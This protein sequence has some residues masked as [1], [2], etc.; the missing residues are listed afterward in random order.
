[1]A[2]RSEA[3]SVD[4]PE[5][6]PPPISQFIDGDPVKVDSPSQTRSVSVIES[7]PK[8]E[9]E[10]SSTSPSPPAGESLSR[11]PSPEK[12][13][14]IKLP[15]QEPKIKKIVLADKPT[16]NAPPPQPAKAGSKRKLAVR[17]EIENSK[18]Q[19]ITNENVPPKS[20]TDKQSIRDKAGGR[21]LKELASIR[22]EAREKGVTITNTRKPLAAKSIND[23][24]SSPKKNSKPA[25]FDEIAA[26]KADLLRS[27]ASH[28]HTKLKPKTP[29]SITVETVLDSRP[30]APKVT[31][32]DCELG[33]PLAEAVLL[34]PSSPEPE[35]SNDGL[36]G[37]TP[38]PA[39]VS[40]TREPGRLSRRN[41][42][43][44]SY[45]EP[46]L[47][48]KMRRPRKELYD[49]VS[50]EGK[51]ARRSSQ[52]DPI[53]PDSVK[54]KNET[55][56]DEAWKNLPMSKTA[57]MEHT[58]DDG[59]ASPLAGKGSPE[60]LPTSVVTDRRRRT[61]T[62]YKDVSTDENGRGKEMETPTDQMIIPNS[63]D[64]D[65]YEF[66]TSS[67]QQAKQES[68]KKP[69]GRKGPRRMSAVQNEEL[70][71]RERTSSRRR[72]MMI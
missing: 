39:D 17:D 43:A 47:R 13:T 22:K 40:S 26:A 57:S 29:I 55:D 41:R 25:L 64:V 72:S 42:T 68:K 33:T 8:P 54:V 32:V 51:Y 70:P 71:I 59:P 23:D 63:S 67:P 66:D 44:V 28:E 45:A 10:V 38:P 65:V 61:S 1:M 24:M 56:T 14:E 21:T 2:L 15:P 7:S 50:G 18:P 49:A 53:A 12:K 20:L 60:N 48:D 37:A 69:A 6:G 4:S 34:S 31:T 3:D 35:T 46:N 52:A 58:I 36:R 62:V 30:I 27:S 5:L 9:L 11:S 19:R 16:T